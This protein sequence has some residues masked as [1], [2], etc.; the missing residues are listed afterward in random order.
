MEMKFWKIKSRRVR[1]LRVLIILGHDKF[2]T[3]VVGKKDVF[4]SSRFLKV[5]LYLAKCFNT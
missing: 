2:P 4:F 5:Q 1:G 3:F